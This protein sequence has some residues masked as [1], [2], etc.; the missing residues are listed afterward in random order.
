MQVA[1]LLAVAALDAY[2]VPLSFAQVAVQIAQP[3]SGADLHDAG[4]RHRAAHRAE[5]ALFA[6]FGTRF[7]WDQTG[8]LRPVERQRSPDERRFVATDGGEIGNKQRAGHLLQ[9]LLRGFFQ[10]LNDRQRRAAHLRLQLGNQ[11]VQQLVPVLVARQDVDIQRRLALFAGRFNA[12]GEIHLQR[13]VVQH[14]FL[15]M[16]N[17]RG[18]AQVIA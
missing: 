14:Y 17:Q 5:L 6:V 16:G 1:A 10:I 18:K 8:H 3:L 2:Y 4:D 9:L 11:R 13:M 15:G 7:S 12:G